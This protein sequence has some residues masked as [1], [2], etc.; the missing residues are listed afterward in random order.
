[1]CEVKG[2]KLG[3]PL[4]NYFN[5]VQKKNILPKSLGFVHKKYSNN[6]LNIQNQYLSLE[7]IEA[8]SKGVQVSKYINHLN[9]SNTN[10]TTKG[11]IMVVKKMMMHK[12]KHLDLSYNP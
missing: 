12:I 6:E 9:M 11:G 2:L 3:N 10:L 8:L 1:M 7:Y 4:V 5:E